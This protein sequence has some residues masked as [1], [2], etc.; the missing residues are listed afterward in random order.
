MSFRATVLKVMI[1]SPGDVAEE[2]GIVTEAIHRWN[3]ANADARRLVLLPVKW[4]THST[5]QL[6]SPAQ[7]VINRQLLDDADIVIGIFGT[8]IGT[9]TED[10]ASGTVEEIKRHVSDGKTAKVYFSD[11]PVA[12][13]AV[14]ATQYAS[15]LEFREDCRTTGL[16]AT[17]NTLE[18]FRSD[19][20]HHLDLE[21][22][23]PRY[24]WLP[25]F[26]SATEPS[27]RH[28]SADAI[29]LLKAAASTDGQII[30]M[31]SLSGDGIRSGNEDFGDGTPRSA[32][33]WRAAL[34]ELLDADAVEEL[35]K[36]LC[37]VTEQGYQIAE[38]PDPANEPLSPRIDP[39][40]EHLNSHVRGI[41]QPLKAPQ[42]DLMRLLL[43]NGGSARTDVI[44][45]AYKGLGGFDFNGLT[46]P[47]VLS[48][49]ITSKEDHLAGYSNLS[50]NPEHTNALKKLLF[51]RD[52][53]GSPNFEGV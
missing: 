48:G 6:G 51:P 35:S 17:Y 34:K 16:Y 40:D 24:R 9:P 37:K 28:L 42:R 2:R 19:L 43:L 32:A 18:Q 5:P 38:K 20:T 50:V 26:E 23:Q 45:R 8:R 27:S 22:N 39:F 30:S 53:D 11:V 44:H 41:I 47:L 29:R 52:D 12:P 13:S 10:Y 1:A 33:R 3:D 4:E 7:T 15:V 49:L 14:N 36:N 46:Q 31:R 21:L 25:T